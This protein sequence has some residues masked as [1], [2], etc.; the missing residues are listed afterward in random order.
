MTEKRLWEA[1]L[2]DWDLALDCREAPRGFSGARWAE[3]Q[4]SLEE[5]RQNLERREHRFFARTLASAEHWRALPEFSNRRA[6]LDI[7]TTGMGSWAQVTVVG[8]YDGQRTRSYIAGENLD[9]FCEDVEQY[10]LL[11]TFNGA[12]FD[13]PFLC[14]RFPR[15]PRDFLHVDLRY[16]LR[17]L[18]YSGGLKAIERRLGMTREPDLAELSGEDAVRLWQE[19][20]AGDAEALERLVRYNAADVEN[21]ELLIDWAYPRLWR[22]ARGA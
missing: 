6:F 4:R 18:G 7:E 12:T 17:R 21:L 22:S 5:S 19:H 3:A 2:E 1:G 20:L 10:A 9:E 8:L 16:V 15:M 14:R 11:A 13:L